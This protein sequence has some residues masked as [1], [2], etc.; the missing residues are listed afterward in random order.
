[1]GGL[2][3]RRRWIILQWRIDPRIVGKGEDENILC[4]EANSDQQRI[5]IITQWENVTLFLMKD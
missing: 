4:D 3:R 2:K 5:V 1:M